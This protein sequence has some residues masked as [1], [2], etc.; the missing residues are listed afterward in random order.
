MAEV[1]IQEHASP[2]KNWKQLLVVAVLV[3]EGHLDGGADLDLA[4]VGLLRADDE[5]EEGRLARAVGPDEPHLLALVQFEAYAVKHD[6]PGV[7]DIVPAIHEI[8]KVYGLPEAEIMNVTKRV[9]DPERLRQIPVQFSW[10][11]QRLVRE[12]H[13]ERLSHA[14]AALY[15]FLLTV[16]DARGLSFYSERSIGRYLAMAAERLDYARKEGGIGP[17]LQPTGDLEADGRDRRDPRDPARGGRGPELLRS[18]QRALHPAAG[19]R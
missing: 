16:A 5:F 13:I 9:L 8:A 7:G 6:V 4:A 3:H 17:V 15:L 19:R 12:R 10:I 18:G 2:I 11:D 14:A 1:Q